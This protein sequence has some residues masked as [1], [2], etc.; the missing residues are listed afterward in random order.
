M[1]TIRHPVLDETGQKLQDILQREYT[2]FR[3]VEVYHPAFQRAP[4]RVP[5]TG[6]IR[7]Y[8]P[9]KAHWKTPYGNTGDV[10]YF[11]AAHNNFMKRFIAHLEEERVRESGDGFERVRLSRSKKVT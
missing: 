1:R 5:S 7:E 10:Y 8:P 9:V 2:N 6:E 4:A 3:I 11:S